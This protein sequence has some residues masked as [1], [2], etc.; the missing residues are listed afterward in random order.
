MRAIIVPPG[1]CCVY[2]HSFGATVLYIGSGTFERAFTLAYKKR[3]FAWIKAIHQYKC[4]SIKV[5]I[6]RCFSDRKRAFEYEKQ[7]IAKLDRKSVV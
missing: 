2:M 5:S 4:K 1:N 7:L 6:L 3:D